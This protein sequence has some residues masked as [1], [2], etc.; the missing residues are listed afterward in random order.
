MYLFPCALYTPTPFCAHPHA[1]QY[2]K[3]F[4]DVDTGDVRKRWLGSM[5][6]CRSQFDFLELMGQTPDAYVS[7]LNNSIV[8]IYKHVHCSTD[9]LSMLL[10]AVIIFD[11]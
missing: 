3:P 5:T 8:V 1:L 4:F 7:A 9:Y 2:Y 11:V 6:Y 10:Q